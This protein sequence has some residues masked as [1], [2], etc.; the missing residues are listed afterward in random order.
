MKTKAIKK[1]CHQVMLTF[2]VPE[3]P[4]FLKWELFVRKIF[5]LLNNLTPSFICSLYLNY[6]I[7]HQKNYVK[8]CTNGV[9]GDHKCNFWQTFNQK[10]IEKYATIKTK[11][12]TYLAILSSSA[13]RHVFVPFQWYSYLKKA[14]KKIFKHFFHLY[15]MENLN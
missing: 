9:I 13:F 11:S 6:L 7:H 3:K 5:L 2:S 15:F 8:I 12:Q 14:T 1:W 4:N 10:N